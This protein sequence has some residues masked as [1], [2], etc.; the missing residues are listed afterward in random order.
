MLA[1][2]L[3]LPSHSTTAEVVD[4]VRWMCAAK[5]LHGVM[6]QL[7]LPEHIDEAAVLRQID[8]EKDVDGLAPANAG[9]M[10]TT[11]ASADVDDPA[12]SAGFRQCTPVGC[13]ELLRQHGVC[14]KGKRV[15]VLGTTNTAGT[16]LGMQMRDLGALSVTLCSVPKALDAGDDA[17][18]ARVKA[19]SR[20]AD[21]LAVMVGHA[22]LVTDE[23]VKPGAAVL[24][25]GINTI[26][27]PDP[28]TGR[29]FTIVGDVAHD[30]VSRVASFLSPVPGGA[31]PMTVSALLANVLLA[32]RRRTA[33]TSASS[34]S[35]TADTPD[36]AGDPCTR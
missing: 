22:E 29:S 27:V 4:A 26:D 12:T 15:V 3:H 17:L 19:I 25:V 33:T 5:H 18:M 31:G 9:A 1:S 35:A 2:D 36:R 32:A 24:D 8:E 28:S 10:M 23:W 34:P 20:E 14:V 6:V 30:A 21:I 7:P 16:P 11:P 13:S